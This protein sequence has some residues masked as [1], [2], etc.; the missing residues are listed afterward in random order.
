MEGWFEAEKNKSVRQFLLDHELDAEE[1]V[2]VRREIAANGGPQRAFINDTPVTLAQLRA[3]S[4]FA[5]DLHP[6]VWYTSNSATAAFKGKCWMRWL[7]TGAAA[8]S[9]RQHLRTIPANKKNLKPCNRNKP[10]QMPPTITINFCSMNW[11][12][13]LWRYETRTRRELDAELKLLKQCRTYQTAT[14]R[15]R[16]A[17]NWSRWK[18]P[19]CSSWNQQ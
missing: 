12:Q 2:M 17:M 19:L 1:M 4:S 11:M 6:A 15:K 5:G 10:P 8:A 9:V 18:Q 13:L 14:G 3:L 7:K 16:Y